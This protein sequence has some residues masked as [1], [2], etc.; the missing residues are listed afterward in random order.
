MV[1]E[2][3]RLFF[4]RIP[5]D[6]QLETSGPIYIEDLKQAA[7]ARLRPILMTSLI[8]ILALMPLALGIGSGSEM[9]RPLA[10]T[11]IAGLLVAVPM[12]LV[13]MPAIFWFIDK[14]ASS[15]RGR[16]RAST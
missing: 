2:P 14:K 7:T 12:V 9:Q 1:L 13:A 11:I 15:W 4:S 8:A 10:I 16:K 6:P 3:I 5:A